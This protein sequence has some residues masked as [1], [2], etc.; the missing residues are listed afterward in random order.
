MTRPG[1]KPAALPPPATTARSPRPVRHDVLALLTLL[2]ITGIVAWNRL[3]FD[4][5][6]GRLDLMTFFL[7]WY[8]FLGQRL[9]ALDVPGWNP[10]LFSG[11]PFAGD[12]ESGWMYAP[13]MLL[14]TLF[15]NA[16]SAFKGMV[17]LHLLI[18]GFS[19]YALCRV[20]GM[21]PLASLTAATTYI[22]GPLLHWTTHCCLIFS[23]FSVWIPLSLL[24]VELAL[25][26]NRWQDRVAPWF[27]S[28]FAISQML[29]GWIGEGWLYAFILPAA[30]TVYR[31]LVSPPAGVP[32]RPF[33]Q[34]LFTGGVTGVAVLVL[35]SALGA[36]GMLPRYFV[37][38]ETNL[39]GGDYSQLG[40]SGVLNPPWQFDYLLA[41][42]I[43]S[44][45]GYH[46]RAAAFGG[47]VTVLFLL[48][49]PMARKRFAVPFFAALT[50]IAMI[51][52]LDTTPLHYLFYLIPRFQEFHD[53]D[54]WRTMSLAAIGPAMLSGAVIE[55]LPRWRGQWRILPVVATALIV[56][57]LTALW[58]TGRGFFVG[59]PAITA[60]LL[61]ALLV[62][63]C[64]ALPDAGYWSTS[65]V[66]PSRAL[67]GLLLGTILLI[68]T[69][70][71]LT[72]TWFGWQWDGVVGRHLARD[73]AISDALAVEVSTTDPGGAGEFLQQQMAANG[74]F[75][76]AG[77][78][79][80]GYPG[81]EA[82]QGSYMGRRLEPAIQAILVN[83]RAI[84]LE[85]DD[86][87]GYNPLQLSR[88][89]DFIAALNGAE[90][91]YHTAF[92]M[93]SGIES[94]LLDLLAVRYILVDASLPQFRP[95][96]QAIRFN[97]REVFRTP[98]V[99][100]YERVSDPPFAWIVHD[101]R[102]VAPDE[103]LLLLSS[104]AVDPYQ[105][106]L[107]ETLPPALNL[108]P[109]AASETADIVRADP[110]SLL[111]QTRSDAPG[112]LVLSQVFASGW[113]AY[114]DGEATPVV[115]TFHA[116]QGIALPA[117]EHTVEFVYDPLSLRVGL[118]VSDLA[119]A[120][121][122]VSFGIAGW[123]AIRL[124]G[125]TPGSALTA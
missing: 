86:I 109:G 111:L 55:S 36:A 114:I 11:A 15:V 60:A 4:A 30:Y 117:G 12:P 13:A 65:A 38:A 34:R 124:R 7:P 2:A 52:T 104:G 68:P 62:S 107:V 125:A 5:W 96:V 91:D 28:G 75:R 22:V 16:T 78:S 1:Q 79:G 24:G 85:L 56:Y 98:E 77:Y 115:P 89:V 119:Y 118:I 73:P 93:P 21:G 46:F 103:S 95:D 90:Q 51:L 41:Q 37:N 54:A 6:L 121:M 101:V 40:E 100:V 3:T 26:A 58:L 74:P 48:A 61:A 120:A 83:G 110:D 19:T 102:E 18:A 81:D 69:G 49:I 39:A 32:P 72:R 88:Y 94:P 87:Q 23:Q 84:F 50:L 66:S 70:M 57:L 53:H 92:L 59:W 31:A 112:F 33:Q 20:L 106:A 82:R 9:R 43:G 10:H 71:E 35:G 17:A 8:D 27:L 105:T 45:A 116:L 99:I 63:V 67:P 29:A 123:R 25:R 47:A 14:F 97:G 108:E 42:T 44:G 113:N 76:Y 80:F 122:L 64:V